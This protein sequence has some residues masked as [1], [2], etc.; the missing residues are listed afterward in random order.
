LGP[1]SGVWRQVVGRPDAGSLGRQEDN[2]EVTMKPTQPKFS[3]QLAK[4]DLCLVNLDHQVSEDEWIR[5]S[6]LNRLQD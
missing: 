1:G 2:P 3:L 5:F 6:C 4:D